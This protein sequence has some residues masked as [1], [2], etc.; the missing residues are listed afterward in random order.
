[1]IYGHFVRYLDWTNQE[2]TR[3]EGGLLQVFLELEEASMNPR[4]I[5]SAIR[6]VQKH[7]P[8]D[9]KEVVSALSW[10]RSRKREWK[11]LYD[12]DDLRRRLRERRRQL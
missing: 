8:C 3:V 9:L 2:A 10:P 1:M 4:L 7:T 5:K 11:L 12:E 6:K